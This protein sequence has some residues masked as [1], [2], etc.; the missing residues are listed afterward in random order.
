VLV[1]VN[2]TNNVSG[3]GM[4]DVDQSGNVTN[5][6][7]PS[8]RTYYLSYFYNTATP[9][10]IYETLSPVNTTTTVTATAQE[11]PAS[12]SRV[13]LITISSSGLPSQVITV[14]QAGSPI[15]D[16]SANS[17]ELAATANS[18]VSFKLN[19]STNW[20]TSSSQSWLTVNKTSGTGNAAI[21]LTAAANVSA[22]AR[23]AT[24]TVSTGDVTKT[25]NVTQYGLVPATVAWN[26]SYIGSGYPDLSVVNDNVVWLCRSKDKSVLY[27]VDG[28]KTWTSKILP[29]RILNVGYKTGFCAVNETTAYIA[30]SDSIGIWKTTDGANTWTLEP[31]GFN[32]NQPTNFYG[33]SFPDF[34]YFWDINNG[35]TYGDDNEVYVT[36]N[37]GAQWNK[38]TSPS[39]PSMFGEFTYNSQTNYRIIGDA[40]YILTNNQ[41]QTNRII[42][43]KDKGLTWSSI[44]P[45]TNTM[46]A[47]FDFKD[48]NNGLYVNY[49]TQ[50]GQIYSTTDGGL[51][52]TL[53]NSTDTIGYV[54]Y[55][56]NQNMYVSTNTDV[57]IKSKFG[58]KYST[59][60]G[61]TW[62]KNP[63]FTNIYNE[64]IAVSPKGTT[65]ITCNEYL[66]SS[67][68][69]TKINTALTKAV[70]KTP[71]TL[72]L[73][74][75]DNIDIVSAQD[76]A[77]YSVTFNDASNVIQHLGVLSAKLDNSNQSLVHLTL[78]NSLP[79]DTVTIK[80]INLIDTK[81][82]PLING[83]LMSEQTQI[84]SFTAVNEIA[85]AKTFIYPNPIKNTFFI[86]GING[87]ALV[88][89]FNTL[90]KQVLTRTTDA[91]QPV[92]VSVLNPGMY[93]IKIATTEGVTERR[94]IKY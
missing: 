72:D 11:N 18:T 15:L 14:T 37:A 34:V 33:S 47:S 38:V 73:T 74:F 6:F 69:I 77:H 41:S 44:Y 21:E 22:T 17:L 56:P 58:I 40:I 12:S 2:D 20:T 52:W 81:G 75:S 76:T 8:T 13:A 29:A 59:D 39:L 27:T 71:T 90:G 16:I 25:I 4:L 42:K 60:N 61:V 53:V 10:K 91:N 83:S 66:Y 80:A 3:Y 5:Y 19:S 64:N 55:I 68:N 84:V 82:Y 85:D 93:L 43:S 54:K 86:N 32:R 67:Q 24:I 65:F 31:T 23:T 46:S 28:G 89:I 35:I 92:N 62:T 49:S 79:Q 88:T 70:V 9:R 51:N 1:A 50:P 30:S 63:T 48:A 7:D 87:S 57:V 45:P 26:Q 78:Q 36:T 94:F